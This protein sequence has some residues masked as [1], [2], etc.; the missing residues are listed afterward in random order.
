MRPQDQTN[1]PECAAELDHC[2]GTL[3]IHTEGTAECTDSECTVTLSCRHGLVVD[4]SSLQPAC[5][6]AEEFATLLRA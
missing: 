5:S 6:C 1:C 3:I 4:C 2:H